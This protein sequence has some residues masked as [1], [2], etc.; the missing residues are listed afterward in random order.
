[1]KFKR[2]IFSDYY[3][4][5][6]HIENIFINEYLPYADGDFVKVYTFA[7]MYAGYD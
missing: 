4:R 7:L 1:M 2:E 6:T 3:L 5:D